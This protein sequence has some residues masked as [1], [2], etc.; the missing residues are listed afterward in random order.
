MLI[1][2]KYITHTKRESNGNCSAVRLVYFVIKDDCSVLIR[3]E[4]NKVENGLSTYINNAGLR[5]QS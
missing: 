4:F 3:F 1:L 5:E 2:V